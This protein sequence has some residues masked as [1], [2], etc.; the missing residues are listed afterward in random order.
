M[1][2]VTPSKPASQ[3]PE[4]VVEVPE[5]IRRTMAELSVTLFAFDKFNLDAKAVEGLNKV[6]TWLK[7]NPDLMV[8]IDGHTDWD[9]SDEYNQGLSERRAKSVYD[10]F[11]SHGVKADR[12]RYKGY[13]ESRPI[14]ANETA[15]G[16]Q[17][18]RRVELTIIQ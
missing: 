11:V 17:Q 9:G 2:T 6:I 1:Q 15:E 16:R 18:N 7:E 3:Q 10:Y 13:G 5:D 14:A 8:Q 4:Q 12:L